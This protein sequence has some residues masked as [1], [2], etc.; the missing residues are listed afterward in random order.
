MTSFYEDILKEYNIPK[1]Q[2][3]KILADPVEAYKSIHR[4]KEGI[5]KIIERYEKLLRK[6]G[7][8]QAQKRIREALLVLRP[9]TIKAN[10]ITKN[11]LSV[12][13]EKLSV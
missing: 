12:K 11:E 8:P 9:S 2:V 5:I 6:T 10:F 3:G 4:K 7:T 13:L 1:S